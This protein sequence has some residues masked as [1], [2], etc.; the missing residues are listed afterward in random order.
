M[1]DFQ[2]DS[3]AVDTA[4]F[5]AAHGQPV[6]KQYRRQR[7]QEFHDKLVVSVMIVV[8]AF[9]RKDLPY[10]HWMLIKEWHTQ[11]KDEA[12][13]PRP[14]GFELYTAALTYCCFNNQAEWIACDLLGK[15]RGRP[16]VTDDEPPTLTSNYQ[17]W[18]LSKFDKWLEIAREISNFVHP[19]YVINIFVYFMLVPML[20]FILIFFYRWPCSETNGWCQAQC[21]QT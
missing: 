11:I 13:H 10:V 21:H 2:D 9:G 12:K 15:G 19:Q 5:S 16:V 17:K 18:G 7:N 20:R 3:A 6:N 4:A 8:K 1:S 14:K